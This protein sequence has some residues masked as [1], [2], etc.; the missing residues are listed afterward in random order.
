LERHY[1]TP[2][3][4]DLKIVVVNSE[5]NIKNALNVFSNTIEKIG[6]IKIPAVNGGRKQIKSTR[7]IRRG[8]SGRTKYNIKISR[9][10]KK[11]IHFKNL[12][13]NL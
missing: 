13:K 4:K 6:E 3:H 7:K 2:K 1:S 11:H 10:M 9:K 8:K 5:E 12:Y